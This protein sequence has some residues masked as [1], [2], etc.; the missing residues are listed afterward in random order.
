MQ[1]LNSSYSRIALARNL[2]A[3]AILTTAFIS[4][5]HA[6]ATAAAADA[7]DESAAVNKLFKEWDTPNSPGCAVAVMKDGRIVYRTRLRHGGSG[8]QHKDHTRDSIQ[9]GL[10]REA[11][12]RNRDLYAGAGRQIVARR[13]DS[14]IR[15]AR[16]PTSASNHVTADAA[17]ILA[18][19]ETTSSCSGSTDGGSIALICSPTGISSY[20]VS[21]QKELNFPP[22]TDYAYSNTN[23]MLLAQVVSHVSGEPFE[24][25]HKD[26]YFRAARNDAYAFPQ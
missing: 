3:I 7:G 15:T 25:F 9:R 18:A 11:V 26:A 14:K 24:Q 23:Y 10:D 12:H 6:R 1:R 16:C 22:G 2:F 20:I 4:I 21:R 8:S 19:C 5:D 13:S 17:L